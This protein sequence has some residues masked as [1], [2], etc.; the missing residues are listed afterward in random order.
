MLIGL[1]QKIRR[2]TYFFVIVYALF[3]RSIFKG[4]KMKNSRLLHVFF[5][6]IF[7]FQL[8]AQKEEGRC[9]SGDCVNGKGKWVTKEYAYEGD[10]KNGLREGYGVCRYNNGDIYDG[11]WKKDMKDGYGIYVQSDKRR[12][13]GDW[14]ENYMIKGKFFNWRGDMVYEGT[15]DDYNSYNS[16]EWKKTIAESRAKRDSEPVKECICD[17]CGG[18][19]KIVIKSFAKREINNGIDSYGNV[20]T[21]KQIGYV[22]EE[23]T[24]TRCLGTG[25]CK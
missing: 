4:L 2:N 21:I 17:K 8:I 11:D 12:F 5:L 23:L 3:L 1:K 16:N 15:P 25:K 7:S 24:C 22:D 9:K 13:D 20:K 19:G 10:F 18:S 14:R 6:L